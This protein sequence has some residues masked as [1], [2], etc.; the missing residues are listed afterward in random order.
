MCMLIS[1]ANLRE[2][3]EEVAQLFRPKEE[4]EKMEKKRNLHMQRNS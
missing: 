4:G 2:H 1:V 3:D